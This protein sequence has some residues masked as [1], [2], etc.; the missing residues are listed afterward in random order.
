MAGSSFAALSLIKVYIA[1]PYP[2]RDA[3]IEMMHVLEANGCRVTSTWL[4]EPDEMAD[5][6]ARLDL[7]DVARADVL[8]AYNPEGWEERGTGGRHVEYG[9]ALGLGIPVV[10]YGEK[11]NIF[12]HL[13]S[14]VHARSNDLVGA[15]RIAHV[16]GR[17]DR[18]SVAL[19]LVAT[20]FL[21]AEAKHA[22]MNS[23]HEGYA[24][25]AEELDELWDHVK[26][27]TGRSAD[28][29][30]EAIQVAAMGLRYF[31]NLTGGGR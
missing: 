7:A 18:K 13:D 25:I 16:S 21:R 4:R 26:A 23:P 5:Q 29:G 20:E 30:N 10:L 17:A 14:V 22:P 9:Y 3:A 19:R 2:C 15:I 6:F 27:D 11:S 28:A 1:A 31:T 12:H 24:V 8:V